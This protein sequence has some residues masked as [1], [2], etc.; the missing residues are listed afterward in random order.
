MTLF[1][2][3][4]VSS[5][6]IAVIDGVWMNRV[7]SDG[8][9]VEVGLMYHCHYFGKEKE[10]LCEVG[11]PSVAWG[12][13]LCLLLTTI[14][15]LSAAFVGLLL[16]MRSEFSRHKYKRSIKLVL[17]VSN[18]VLCF[19][20]IIHPVGFNSP[21]I[22]GNAYVFPVDAQI[23]HSYYFVFVGLVFLVAAQVSGGKIIPPRF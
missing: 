5:L 16:S 19:A 9:G 6:V 13:V 18:A 21:L 2:G 4:T 15:L 1:T 14:L 11:I 10:R 22:G 23:G 17:F 3:F 7:V 8:Y 20:S 12:I